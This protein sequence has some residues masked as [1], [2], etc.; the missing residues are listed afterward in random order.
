MGREHAVVA[1]HMKP[2]WRDQGTQPRDEVERVEHHRVHTILP[3]VPKAVAA[4]TVGGVFEALLSEWRPCDVAAQSLESLAIT[5][6]HGRA[7]VHV[8]ST[9]V[10]DRSV[11]LG[12]CDGSH[13]VRELASLLPG[14]V[15]RR[16]G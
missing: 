7:R 6:G 2:W 12:L 11:G 4:A 15:A 5:A 9:D 16:A 1:Q 3:C 14:R 8:D 10:G 13:R